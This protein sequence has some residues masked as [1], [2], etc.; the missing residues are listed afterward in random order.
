MVRSDTCMLRIRGQAAVEFS[1]L[2][3]LW[4]ADADP[5]ELEHRKWDIN[6]SRNGSKS[7]DQDYLKEIVDYYMKD[8]YKQNMICDHFNEIFGSGG[9]LRIISHVQPSG[10]WKEVVNLDDIEGF[11]KD[12]SS[13]T[14]SP[15]YSEPI[16]DDENSRSGCLPQFADHKLLHHHHQSPTFI[17]IFLILKAL[18]IVHTLTT[19]VEDDDDGFEHAHSSFCITKFVQVKVEEGMGEE[20]MVVAGKMVVD[21]NEMKADSK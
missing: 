12:S 21:N 10:A 11:I 19:S 14:S 17:V 18:L 16:D 5:V 4:I 13:P 8:H 6:G 7:S 20:E 15:I 2:L 1:M 3:L 9:L